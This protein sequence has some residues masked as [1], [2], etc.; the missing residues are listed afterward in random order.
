MAKQSISQRALALHTAA[1]SHLKEFAVPRLFALITTA[2]RAERWLTLA[3]L[4]LV[5]VALA[6]PAVS[7]FADYHAF[8]D[9]R[10]LWGIPFAMDVL[11]NLPFV[12]CGV[13][14]LWLLGRSPAGQDAA[15]AATARV[16]F[17]GLCLTAVGSSYYH[18]QPD[19]MGLLWDRLGM[20]PAFA[21]LLALAVAER[22]SVRAA[23]PVCA[24]LLLGGVGS[25]WV[26]H[27][28]GNLLPWV[29]LQ[30]GGMLACVLL[31]LCA[32]LPGA[33]GVSV[34][35]VVLIYALAKV[36]ELADHA[37][38]AWTQDWLGL[39]ISGH[40]LKHVVAA[41]AAVPVLRVMHN[42]SPKV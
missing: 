6:G 26:W 36:F 14:G 20:V 9:Q 10:A 37:V 25:V 28:T 29:V 21:G 39:G 3:L 12:V 2:T 17:A 7:Q 5:A 40:S 4:T 1:I 32:R 33:W 11:T 16:F 18:W 15:R 13:W 19:N 35:A 30:G 24:A 27:A 8:A 22:V 34:V 38:F 31:A 23:L 41:L 42:G